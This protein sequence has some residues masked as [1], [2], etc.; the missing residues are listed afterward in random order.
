MTIESAKE[1]IRALLEKRGNFTEQG[2]KKDLFVNNTGANKVGVDI[3]GEKPIVGVFINGV[4]EEVGHGVEAVYSLRTQIMAIWDKE[5][6]KPPKCPIC[7]KDMILAV[8]DVA[9][10]GEEIGGVPVEGFVCEDEAK[11]KATQPKAGVSYEKKHPEKK[12]GEDTKVEERKANAPEIVIPSKDSAKPPIKAQPEPAEVVMPEKAGHRPDAVVPANVFTPQGH[13]IKTL[14]P[15]LK[16]IGKIK[17][18]KK[19]DKKTDS[20]YKLPMKF[21][22]FEVTSIMRGEGGNFLPDPIMQQLGD[23]PKELNVMFLYND[24][25]LIFSTRFN[26][27]KGGKCQCSGDGKVATTLTG[28]EIVCNPEDPSRTICKKYLNKECKKNG[29]LS[30]ILTDSPRLGGVYKFRTTSGNSINSIMAALLLYHHLTG[31]VLA[32][33]PFKLTVSPMQVQPEN[34]NT[35][36]TIYV[37]NVEFAGNAGQLLEKTI[38]V[39]KYQGAMRLQI[40]ENENHAKLALCEPESE[41]E[42]KDVEV[43]FQYNVKEGAKS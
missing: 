10:G 25:T 27:Y 28:E 16:E 30:C 18:G 29:I 39:Q 40:Q 11:H 6:S 38:E 26:A 15:R 8:I 17:I 3:F 32:M 43:E 35:A 31:G 22:H 5:V 1:K 9:D 19:G 4:L 14:T 36:Q 24:P 20:G 23:K 34:S 13:Y 7:K 42:I 37:V 12:E 2:M 33:I 41:E 21:D